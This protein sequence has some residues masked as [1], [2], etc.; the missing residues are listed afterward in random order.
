MQIF[1]I[2]SL[3]IAALA[4]IFAIQNAT[5]TTV[6][7]FIW[8]FEGSLALI[9]LIALIAGALISLFAS[10]PALIKSKLAVTSLNKKLT[11]SET[12]IQKVKAQVPAETERPPEQ[13]AA[14]SGTTP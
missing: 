3:I 9:L 12:E 5:P 10:M 11:K 14:D 8:E 1:L 4:T 2:I 7:F 13:S 6:N